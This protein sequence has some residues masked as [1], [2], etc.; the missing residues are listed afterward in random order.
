MAQLAVI[1]STRVLIVVVVF[2]LLDEASADDVVR[3]DSVGE[4]RRIP[5]DFQLGTGRRV[6]FQTLG[7]TRR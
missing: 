2:V 3:H 6:R 7:L 5:R 1:T 4:F